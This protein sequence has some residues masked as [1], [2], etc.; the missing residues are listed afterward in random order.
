MKNKR[1]HFHGP[2]SFYDFAFRQNKR[3]DVSGRMWRSNESSAH[4]NKDGSI[5]VLGTNKQIK[6]YVLGVCL[7]HNILFVVYGCETWVHKENI[8]QKLSVFE[9]KILRKIFGSNK[10]KDGSWIMKGP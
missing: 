1:T 10:K 5:P 2:F 3:I 6:C 7:K 9:R 8:T 4:L